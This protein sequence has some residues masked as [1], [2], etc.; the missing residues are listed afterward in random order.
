MGEV[1]IENDTVR[2]FCVW[3]RSTLIAAS[4]LVLVSMI[5]GIL[6]LEGKFGPSSPL[7]AWGKILILLQGIDSIFLFA[8]VATGIMFWKH[9]AR[10]SRCV[11]IGWFISFVLPI[12]PALFPLELVLKSEVRDSLDPAVVVSL[13]F[14]V[15]LGYALQLLP[16]V[17]TFPGG[18]VRAALRVRALFPH[19][20]LAG[21]ILI[22][23]APFYSVVVLVALVVVTQVAGN[24]LLFVGTAM[25]VCSPWIYVARGSLFVGLSTPAVEKQI[26]LTYRIGSGTFKLGVVV[27]VIW[28]LT[29]YVSGIRPVGE[30]KGAEDT[31]ISLLT[32]GEAVR[33]VLELIGRL[34]VTTILFADLILAMVLRNWLDETKR[35]DTFGEQS[36]VD[37]HALE[38]AI[39]QE[40]KSL[41]TKDQLTKHSNNDSLEPTASV[42]CERMD[43]ST[44]NSDNSTETE[45]AP[46]EVALQDEE[47]NSYLK[48]RNRRLGGDENV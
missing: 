42:D 35:R 12:F 4:P 34:L 28:A 7:N 38:K 5:T 25:V 8:A 19:S 37:F 36:D 31:G 16:V 18:A 6:N 32:Y 24:T 13:K 2:A 23:C 29:A 14:S 3:R 41:R 20:S 44:G 33:V 17:I 1:G 43:D 30:S 45:H 15:A 22:M 48:D 40:T 9:I 11:R 27:V 26:V 10:S 47:I 46:T 39:G 21:W